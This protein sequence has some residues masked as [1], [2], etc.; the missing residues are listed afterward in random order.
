LEEDEEMRNKINIYKNN[1]KPQIPVDTDD[2][3]DPSM[4]QISL[5]EMLDDLV[6]DDVNMGD[7]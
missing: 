1:R 7:A 4:P 3:D 2:M 5:E 6:I